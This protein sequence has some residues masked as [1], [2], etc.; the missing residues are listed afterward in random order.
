MFA[1]EVTFHR[2][3]LHQDDFATR[4]GYQLPMSY[5]FCPEGVLT[6]MGISTS[7]MKDHLTNQPARIRDE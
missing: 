5:W 6:Y 7:K 1:T 4:M 2:W 3:L